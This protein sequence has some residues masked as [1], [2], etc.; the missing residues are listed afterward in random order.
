MEWGQ[1]TT[2]QD[3]ELE[4]NGYINWPWVLS[5]TVPLCAFLAFSPPPVGHEAV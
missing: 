1:F 3:L 5:L 2:Q 4:V